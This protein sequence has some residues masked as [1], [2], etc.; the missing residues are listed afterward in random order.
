MISGALISAGH[1]TGASDRHFPLDQLSAAFRH[2]ESSK[3]FGK[4]IV[5]I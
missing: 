2:Q 1:S 5:N 3:H 4:I